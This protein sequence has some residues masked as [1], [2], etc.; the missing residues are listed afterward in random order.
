LENFGRLLLTAGTVSRG[1]QIP[2]S[3]VPGVGLVERIF[4]F[5][6]SFHFGVMMSLAL[7]PK[8]GYGVLPSY[9]FS[10][11]SLYL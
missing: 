4:S 5:G 2:K 7:G 8:P 3:Q 9:F 1:D 11:E 10:A 6:R